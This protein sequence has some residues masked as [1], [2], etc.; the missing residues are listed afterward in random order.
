VSCWRV[1]SLADVAK[2]GD[3]DLREPKH[4]RELEALLTGLDPQALW[5]ALDRRPA[6]LE[7]DA[8]GR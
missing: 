7:G 1:V 4:A 6:D 8:V 3:L 5:A 2:P